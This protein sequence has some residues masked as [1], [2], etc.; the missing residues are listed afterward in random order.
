[1]GEIFPT[2]SDRP[3]D[4]HHFL[5]NGYRVPFPWRGVDKVPHL[6][7][8]LKKGQRREST[9]LLA[10][11][12]YSRVNFK[13]SCNCETKKRGGG[14]R[15][16]L[17]YRRELKLGVKI[18]NY[19]VCVAIKNPQLHKTNTAFRKTGYKHSTSDTGYPRVRRG[20]NTG[21]RLRVI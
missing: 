9:P 15:T 13:V 10:F 12:A 6:A 7:P 19:F 3:R 17:Q 21:Q 5:Y 1:M 14:F 4:P 16:P 8:R 18:G 20:C 2:C 11:V